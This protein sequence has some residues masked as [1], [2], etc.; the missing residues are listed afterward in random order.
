MKPIEKIKEIRIKE[1]LTQIQFAKKYGLKDKA[2]KNIEN[3]FQ[4]MN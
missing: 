1:N 4:K 2:I 3:G